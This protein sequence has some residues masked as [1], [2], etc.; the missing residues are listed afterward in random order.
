MLIATGLH[1]PD[2][3]G[4]LAELVGDPWV[5]ANVAVADHFALE[6]DHVMMGETP[7]HRVPVG[8]DRRFVAADVET[9]TG[10]VEPHFMAGRSGGRKVIAPGVAHH[11]TIRT[12][13]S[14]RLVEDPGAT[15][16]NL[17]GNPLH[18][19]RLEI[20]AVPDGPIH[21]LDT[22]SDEDRRL[23]FAS[24]GEVPKSRAAAVELVRGAI[25]VRVP[26]EFRTVVTSAVGCPLDR[27]CY[28]T[29][30][31]MV[32]P[33]DILEEGG[34]LAIVSECGEG[35]GSPH[36]R[37]AQERLVALGPDAFLDTLTAR[38]LADIDEWQTEMQ[39][40]PMRVGRIVLVAPG[41]AEADRAVTGLR[42][43]DGLAAAVAEGIEGGPGRA[44]AV[45]P[46]GPHVAPLHDGA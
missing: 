2:E 33:I 41:L 36:F 6:D 9:A 28:Q 25:A 13:H 32:T 21:A 30:K 12:V 19:A 38:S 26:R 34:A 18:E 20:T 7:T 8:L 23:A 22:V 31:G 14:A 3:G 4:E 39:F 11:T 15:S 37:A 24:L 35:I 45:I 44:V 29:V 27:T 1:R 17:E 43:R 10:P 5:L 40:E 46:E 42:C 16:R